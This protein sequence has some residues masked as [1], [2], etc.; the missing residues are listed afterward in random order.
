MNFFFKLDGLTAN[1]T[2]TICKVGCNLLFLP[3]I[4]AVGECTDFVFILKHSFSYHF[5]KL[6]QSMRNVLCLIF[7]TFQLTRLEF[8]ASYLRVFIWIFQ[9]GLSTAFPPCGRCGYIWICGVNLHVI[10]IPWLTMIAVV[11]FLLFIGWFCLTLTLG[12][13]VSSHKKRVLFH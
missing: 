6:V 7:V 5:D 2:N 9:W 4:Y 8:R 13:S 1:I 11:M 12:P 10:R 3:V